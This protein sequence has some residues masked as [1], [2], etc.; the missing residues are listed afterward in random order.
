[1]SARR[2]DDL[3]ELWRT[4]D[5]RAFF[6]TMTTEEHIAWLTAEQARRAELRKQRR[7]TMRPYIWWDGKKYFN[8]RELAKLRGTRTNTA[9]EWAK[10]RPSLCRTRAI[11]RGKPHLYCRNEPN[12]PTETTRLISIDHEGKTYFSIAELARRHGTSADNAWEWAMRHRRLVVYRNGRPY[13]R[14]EGY[15][16][17]RAPAAI[18]IDGKEYYSLAELARRRG[19]GFKSTRTWAKLRPHLVRR[20]SGFIYVQDEGYEPIAAAPVIWDGQT[21][22]FSV[23]ALARRRNVTISAAMG[24]IKRHPE[25]SKRVG[26]FWYAR[27]EAWR[28][29][30]N[31]P[32]PNRPP[33]LHPAILAQIAHRQ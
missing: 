9:R 24:W 1:M 32:I 7:R 17:R 8:M 22:Y 4:E 33:A 27:D 12:A 2:P 23:S 10:R 6:R 11:G 20:V 3:R 18:W 19:V 31:H 15:R 21:P 26:K 16:P 28:P 29:R 5:L 25:L 14:D 13:C 30:A